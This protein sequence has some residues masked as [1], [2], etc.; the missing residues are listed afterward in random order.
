VGLDE[1]GRLAVG[2]YHQAVW[3]DLAWRH[4]VLCRAENPTDYDLC[5]LL[6]SDTAILGSEDVVP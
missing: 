6:L 2:R 5:A 3:V 1:R 4:L